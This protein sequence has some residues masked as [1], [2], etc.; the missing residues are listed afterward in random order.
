MGRPKVNPLKKIEVYPASLRREQIDWLNR[1]P[2]FRVHK[3]MRDKLDKYIRQ[4]EELC[5]N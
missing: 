4:R 2:N 5:D 3:F 1:H